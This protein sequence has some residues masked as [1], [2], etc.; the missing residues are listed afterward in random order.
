VAVWCPQ[1]K[2]IATGDVLHGFFPYIGDAYPAEWPRTLYALAELDFRQVIGGHAGVQHGRDRLYH[3]AA[4]LDDIT[5]QVRRGKR[6]GKRLADLEASITPSTL[7]SLQRN[8][9]GDFIMA[10]NMKYRPQPPGTRPS[11]TLAEGVKANVAH[12]L[13]GLERS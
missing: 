8:G 12:V 3:M 13:A 7:P 11:D 1:K 2:V 10:S 4:Y 6:D 5:E 9:Y